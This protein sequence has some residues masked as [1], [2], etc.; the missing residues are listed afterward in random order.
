MIACLLI[1]HF[2]IK[3]EFA[4]NPRLKGRPCV[5]VSEEKNDL[6]VI[7]K[8]SEAANIKLGM[9][10]QSAISIYKDL[11]VLEADYDMY[12]DVHHNHMVIMNNI[13]PKVSSD[14]LGIIMLDITG[15]EMLYN[16]MNNLK[17]VLI[18]SVDKEF[19]PRLGISDSSFFSY[20]GALQCPPNG[21]MEILDNFKLMPEIIPDMLPIKPGNKL[22]L[23]E[24]G[25]S[26]LK[27]LSNWEM[28]YLQVQFGIQE[29]KKIWELSQGID[30]NLFRH[31]LIEPSLKKII[32]ADE[33][34]STKQSILLAISYGLDDLLRNPS[35]RNRSARSISLNFRTVDKQFWKKKINFKEPLF[36]KSKIIFII[37]NVLE[38]VEMPGPVERIIIELTG[39]TNDFGIQKSMF[40]SSK[41]RDNLLENIKQLETRLGTKV[42][43]YQVKEIEPCSKIPE[44][45]SALT[46][47]LP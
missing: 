41:K 29:G 47:I 24:L 27:Q 19:N 6:V 28:S 8:S 5:V 4:R 21:C 16:G 12:E 33:Y 42:P 35:F 30:S 44:R 45:R 40:L 2:Y 15:L 13:C 46:R 11:V 39:L 31:E 26:N 34:F 10:Y 7:D 38:T 17:K 14:D 1:T 32:D 20:I 36:M 3:N 18:S 23:K 43:I 37:S 22:K 9:S 25:I